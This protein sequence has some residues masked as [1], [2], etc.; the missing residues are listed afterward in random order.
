M[1]SQLLLETF[2]PPTST[3]STIIH[4]LRYLHLSSQWSMAISGSYIGGTYH[5]YKAYLRHKYGLTWYS[6]SKLE[7][8]NYHWNFCTVS[9]WY[10]PVVSPAAEHVLHDEHEIRHHHRDGS[11][12]GFQA[13]RQLGASQ[14]ARVHG[15]EDTNTCDEDTSRWDLRMTIT[16]V[17]W[18][19]ARHFYLFLWPWLLFLWPWLQSQSLRLQ[20]PRR[21]LWV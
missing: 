10:P 12:E 4:E 13:L 15:D 17:Q 2:I 8:W 6:T 3:L 16:N 11:E 14:V 21:D 7:S 1:R 9:Q 5:I 18:E 20:L 19:N